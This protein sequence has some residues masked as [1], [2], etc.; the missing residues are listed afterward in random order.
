[1]LENTLPTIQRSLKKN[2]W[3][4]VFGRQKNISDESD[5]DN[6]KSVRIISDEIIDRHLPIPSQHTKAG[7]KLLLSGDALSELVP[8]AFFEKELSVSQYSEEAVRKLGVFL[9]NP[10]SSR[11]LC[12]LEDAVKFIR[13]SEPGFTIDNI[14]VINDSA[15]NLIRR[16]ET[17]GI[18]F[19]HNISFL[20][21][22]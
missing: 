2:F 5:E 18:P 19:F 12:I 20:K 8:Q 4:M 6:E 13:M 16:G 7:E 17:N 15:L 22:N 21:R 3:E 11:S 9:I 10:N 1:M 14:S